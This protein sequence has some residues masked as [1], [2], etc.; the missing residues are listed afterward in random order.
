[1]YLKI[2]SAFTEIVH[3]SY[4]NMERRDKQATGQ[5]VSA[6]LRQSDRPSPALSDIHSHKY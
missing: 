6:W 1:M 5:V 2:C 4:E 3:G